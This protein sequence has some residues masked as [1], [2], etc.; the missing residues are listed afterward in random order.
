MNTSRMT[1]DRAAED[2]QR[3]LIGPHDP[4]NA[5]AASSQPPGRRVT[6]SVTFRLSDSTAACEEARVETL[7]R[8]VQACAEST[9]PACDD[10]WLI[11]PATVTN[12]PWAPDDNPVRLT[13]ASEH[14]LSWLHRTGA[15]ALLPPDAVGVLYWMLMR[16]ERRLGRSAAIGLIPNMNSK[17]E[18][19][20]A[21]IA[22]V[23]NGWATLSSGKPPSESAMGV[24]WRRP[25]RTE[26]RS[27]A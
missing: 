20:S 5:R 7:R 16:D 6:I 11:R 25:I 15:L 9:F 1:S 2:A 26:P 21:I 13:L 22:L 14:T 23:S 19:R 27:S 18:P 24:R 12:D 4:G 10:G 17:R 8:T 3:S